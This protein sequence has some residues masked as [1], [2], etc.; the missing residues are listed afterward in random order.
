M[1]DEANGLALFDV[2]ETHY[3]DVAVGVLGAAFPNFIQHFLSGGAVEQGEFPHCPI[4][5]FSSRAF[6]KFHTGNKAL[7]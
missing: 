5:H 1:N 6:A 7:L 2:V 4:V 3:F